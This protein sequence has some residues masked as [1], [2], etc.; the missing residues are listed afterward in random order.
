M[1]WL[2]FAL[3]AP[4]LMTLINFS[5]KFMMERHVPHAGALLLYF[6]F[7]NWVLMLILWVIIGM[8]MLATEDMLLLMF[9][10]SLNVIGNIFYFRALSH[11]DTSTIT[12]LLQLMPVM[13]LIL[14]VV[15]LREVPTVIQFIGFVCIIV[16]AIG[17][18]YRPNTDLKTTGTQSLILMSL[19]GFIWALSAVL[20]DSVLDR[21]VVDLES[22]FIVVIYTGLGYLPAGLLFYV[23]Q[24]DARR[25]FNQQLRKTRLRPL[26]YILGIEAIFFARQAT[27]FMAISL[28]SVALVS[29]L[30]ATSIFFGIVLGILFTI[31]FPAIYHEDIR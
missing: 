25:A 21:V 15:L 10:G 17:I 7:V 28:G 22:L 9:T 18:S 30:G 13:T 14:S 26:P 8:P 6:T 19:T 20:A 29:V 1:D 5:D 2:L 12:V 24:P 16:A 27:L 23:S 11:E 3:L 31:L 4:L